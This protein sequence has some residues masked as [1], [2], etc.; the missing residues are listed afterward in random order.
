MVKLM[1][2]L[3]ATSSGTEHVGPSQ[4]EAVFIGMLAE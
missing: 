2:A 3:T 4:D 1:E